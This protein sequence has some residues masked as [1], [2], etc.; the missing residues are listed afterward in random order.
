ME[1]LVLEQKWQLI[2]P[3]FEM[4]ERAKQMREPNNILDTHKT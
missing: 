3:K 2:Y 4:N 1:Y